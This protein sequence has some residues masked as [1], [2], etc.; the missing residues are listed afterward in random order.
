MA[1]SKTSRK[2]ICFLSDFGSDS[3]YVAEVKGVIISIYKDVQIIDLTHAVTPQNILEASFLLKKT[4][5]FFPKNTVFLTVVDPGVG[6][7]RKI[8]LVKTKNYYFLAPDN[9]LIYETVVEE[10]IENIIGVENKSYFL[11]K[12][13]STFHGRDIFAPVLAHFLKDFKMKRF[14]KIV[15]VKDIVAL[16]LPRPLIKKDALFAQVMHIDSFGNLVTN[17]R[18]EKFFDFI[19]KKKK[20][21]AILNNKKITHY[22]ENYLSGKKYPFFIEGSFDTLEISLN[23][24]SAK[25]YFK[26]RIGDMIKIKKP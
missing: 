18:K 12:V 2:I 15:D 1:S 26:A 13:S 7:E 9:G 3:V 8:I 5:K 4:Y 25:V 20:F 16:N 23:K 22:C 14:G 17:L 24:S 19:G 6:T 10:D 11:K 21:L